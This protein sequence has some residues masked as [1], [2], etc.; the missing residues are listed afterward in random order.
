M[1]RK[2]FNWF[3]FYL[4]KLQGE[5]ESDLKNLLINQ[6]KNLVA[7]STLRT[8][9]LLMRFCRD[10]QIQAIRELSNFRHIQYDF[11][12]DLVTENDFA[13]LSNEVKMIYLEVMCEIDSFKVPQVIKTRDFPLEAALKVCKKHNHVEA[14]IAINEKLGRV[15][16]ALDLFLDRYEKKGYLTKLKD[17]AFEK[18]LQNFNELIGK[19][20]ESSDNEL[21]NALFEKTLDK[22][23]LAIPYGVKTEFR[24]RVVETLI[25]VI[26]RYLEG[27][28]TYS[29]ENYKRVSDLFSKLSYNMTFPDFKQFLLAVLQGMKNNRN[30]WVE[31]EV[32]HVTDGDTLN[33]H[34]C[35]RKK[36]GTK[37]GHECTRC[38]KKLTY[39][40]EEVYLFSCEH[41]FHRHCLE[42]NKC[43]VCAKRNNYGGM[44]LVER[45]KS[46]D[47]LDLNKL[48]KWNAELMADS[49]KLT[50]GLTTEV[51]SKAG[52][53]GSSDQF[54][55]FLYNGTVSTVAIGAN[56]AFGDNRENEKLILYKTLEA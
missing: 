56:M 19:I 27:T 50:V 26:M 40:L 38:G 22:L 21:K 54:L 10:K 31:Y 6:T 44:Q 41:V 32:M 48:V 12:R 53:V 17:S 51:A 35:L 11:I 8:Q 34:A 1:Q 14:V 33:A 42:S 3:E 47:I 37:V 2:I 24:R 20:Y 28:F 36:V 9:D 4:N 23:S 16:D 45:E 49:M 52:E 29:H 5:D 18:D 39:K 25:E 7:L 13:E 43:D 30:I 15:S 46:L 55:K